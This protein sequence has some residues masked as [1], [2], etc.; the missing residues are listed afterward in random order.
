VTLQNLRNLVARFLRSHNMSRH[1]RSLMLWEALREEDRAQA[2]PP[3]VS[4][5]LSQAAHQPWPELWA[6][7]QASPEGLRTSELAA[8]HEQWGANSVGDEAPRAWW[9]HLLACYANPFSLLLT[10]LAWVSWATGD[11]RA[12]SVIVV[13]VSL[14]TGVRFVQERRS[15]KAA[16]ALKAMVSNRATA[17][18]RE[19]EGE[20]PAKGMEV[21]MADLVPGDIVHLAAGDMV[22]AD[23]RIIQAKD[24]FISQSAMTGE[25]LPVEKRADP[26]SS[27][28]SPLDLDNL[29]FMGT[30]VTSGT[31]QAVVLSTG[32]HTYFGQLAHRVTADDAHTTAFQAGINKVSWLLIRFMLV[33]VPLVLLINGLSKGNWLEALLFALSIAVG[34]TPEMLPMIVTSTL[35]KGAV[36][37]SRKRVIVKRLDAIQN[38]GAMDVL[39]TD[40]TGT[41]TQDKVA[42]QLHTDAYGQDDDQVL[43]LVYLNSHF[44]TGL[45]NLLDV[46]VL[47][48]AALHSD[49]DVS[50]HYRM[51]DE[52][53]FDFQRR[54]MSVVVC[55][56]EDHHE[57]ICKGA[58]EEVLQVC[59]HVREGAADVPLD[60]DRLARIQGASAALNAQGMRVVAVACKEEP[61]HRQAYSVADE[62]GLVLVGY[63]AFL[64]P[65]KES[66]A[67][68][69]K[70][71]HAHGVSLKILTGDNDRVTAKVCADVGLDPGVI[72]MGQD[73][74]KMDDA[75]LAQAVTQHRVFAK[76]SPDQKER[77]VAA[78]QAQGH[79]VGYMGDG[80]NDAAALRRADIGISV[81][82]AVDIAKAAADIILLEKSLMVLQEGVVEGRRVF[83]NM[84]K[85]IKMTAS[86]NFGNVFSVLLASAFLP[87]LP[88]LPMQ[89]LVQ[90][91]LYDFSQT[92]IPFD[93]VDA[94]QVVKPQAWAAAD[95]GRFMLWFG[96]VSSVFDVATFAFM[97]WGLGWQGGTD[98]SSFQTGWFVEGLLSQ[99][100]IVHLIRTRKMPFVH[101]RAAPALVITTVAVAALGL[102]LAQGPWSAAL[103]MQPLPAVY[104]AGLVPL[105]LG[106]VALAQVVKSRYAARFDWS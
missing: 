36:A 95:I 51:V 18:R 80:I 52:I 68:A 100:L 75:A 64:D 89:L 21:P 67:P 38:F 42:L 81:D 26:G 74:A 62:A 79:V 20:G 28:A 35:A 76:L 105:L 1:F 6:V 16:D 39:C 59:T 17:W 45:K 32:H 77:I 19:G 94:E 46:A 11:V 57:L 25:A 88:M 91:L 53:P 97:W 8:R 49:L 93:R 90:N 27:D 60:A 23:A 99:V 96:P 58:T 56:R 70:A 98:V 31:A 2:M 24:L 43:S 3:G 34:L 72:L 37:L 47:A 5:A 30:N 78:L 73:I 85:Y 106:Y 29:I 10:V 103:R 66:T 33:M 61:P 4:Q 12:M 71:L 69:L 65:P 41:L 40:K 14:S 101:S 22:P 9:R 102:L 104:F 63:I 92:A 55:E 7:L 86:S 48:N 84:V 44:Q 54:R 15:G 83:A 13:M 50:T 87:F 82:S